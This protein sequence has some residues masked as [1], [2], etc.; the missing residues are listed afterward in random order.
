VMQR[1]DLWL[2]PFTSGSGADV[3]CQF[4]GR[5]DGEVRGQ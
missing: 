2:V 3:C 4:A 1:R 5:K